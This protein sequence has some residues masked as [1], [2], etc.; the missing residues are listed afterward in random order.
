MDS[1]SIWLVLV[2]ALLL[3]VAWVC[4]TGRWRRWA[5]IAML[6]M[7][8]IAAAPGLGLCFVLGGLAGPLPSPLSGVCIG[9][10]LLA[11]AIS[12]WRMGRPMRM[13]AVLLA[14][15]ESGEQVPE[16]VI[17]RLVRVYAGR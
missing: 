12:V 11:L 5:S 8:P 13:S 4:W 7:M 14:L 17:E 6:P 9:V 16:R 15:G 10:G 3:G 2:G 1:D